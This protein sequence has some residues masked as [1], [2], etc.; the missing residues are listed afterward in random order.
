MTIEE[1]KNKKE[2]F[3]QNVYSLIYNFERETGCNM[4][5]IRLHKIESETGESECAYVTTTVRI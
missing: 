2:N 3:E 5:D 4:E 1:V